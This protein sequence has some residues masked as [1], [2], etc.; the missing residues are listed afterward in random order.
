MT[1]F[2][3]VCQINEEKKKRRE[4]QGNKK[5]FISLQA[6]KQTQEISFQVD[7]KRFL[8]QK[9]Q[10]KTPKYFILKALK[11]KLLTQ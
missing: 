2:F 1:D 3:L 10:I 9:I 11:W 4:I 7:L 6:K 8:T 5:P